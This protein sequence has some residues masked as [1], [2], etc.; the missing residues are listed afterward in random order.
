MDVYWYTLH[1]ITY[2]YMYV[3][4]GSA[5]LY[6]IEGDAYCGLVPHIQKPVIKYIYIQDKD[7]HTSFEW[8]PHSHPLIH[9]YSVHVVA[10]HAPLLPHGCTQPWPALGCTQPWPDL[11][12]TCACAIVLCRVQGV[13]QRNGTIEMWPAVGWARNTM[14]S[15]FASYVLWTVS[16]ALASDTAHPVFICLLEARRSIPSW[17]C[18]DSVPLP[19]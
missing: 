13:P 17:F 19:F 1:W 14:F 6:L 8:S 5:F 2:M 18:C 11:E 7:F 16:K 4:F 15:H 9:W 12:L 3:A 10:H